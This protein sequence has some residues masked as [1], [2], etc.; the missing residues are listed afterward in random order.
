MK[1]IAA[2]SG[3]SDFF[4]WSEQLA[5]GGQVLAVAL[6]ISSTA[7]SSDVDLADDTQLSRGAE[8]L[9]PFKQDLKSALVS[10]L[11]EGS[12]HALNA[13][14]AQAPQIANRLSSDGV[15]MGRASHRLRNP[16]NQPPAWLGGIMQE[17]LKAD[18]RLEPI[19]ISLSEQRI[20]YVE[21]ILVQPLC[22]TCHGNAL[23][24]EVAN[25]IEEA[26]PDDQAVGFEVGDL[27]GVYW[28]TYPRTLN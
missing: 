14:K 17:Y 13:C 23:A 16:A 22:L 1:R 21:P 26:Y 6:L 15:R 28:V 11:Q 27:R 18:S 2:N 19:A 3:M 4:V 20:G 25:H 9:L 24:P 12:V 10:G 8:L 5:W 7:C